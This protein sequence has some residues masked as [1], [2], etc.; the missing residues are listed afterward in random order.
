VTLFGRNHGKSRQAALWFSRV[1]AG[2][3][4]DSEDR[5]WQQWMAAEADNPEA[6]DNVELAWQLA[7]ELR[8]RPQIQGLLHDIDLKFKAGPAAAAKT[9]LFGERLSWRAAAGIAALVLVCVVTALVF[10]TRFGAREY[11]TA[12]GEQRTMVLA[13][14][15]RISLNT[16]TRVQVRY[17][18]ALRHIDL[19]GGEAVFTVTP[20]S[21][22]PFEV[23]ALRGTTTAVGT[24]FDVR[25]TGATAEVSV[26]QGEVTVRPTENP[27]DANA[28]E[29]FAGQAEEY[30][31]DGTTSAIHG[32]DAD[33]IHG[34]LT[35]R[36]V[37]GDTALA[38][39]LA[40]YNRYT[41]TPIV[42]GKPSLGERRISGVFRIGDQAAFLNALEQ[43]LTVTATP[44]GAGIVLQPR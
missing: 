12:V 4:D 42:I 26:L 7:E 14:N 23:H 19:L 8:D 22:R 20:D 32:A 16:G 5:D 39:A 41:K 44:V 24:E 40:D 2:L 25:V 30:A 35:Q 18:G 17:S 37:F 31:V 36:I 33:K 29:I 27:N 9:G 10:K 3:E 15:S 13:D 43:Q 6:Y 11:A 34:W 1:R 38:E 28:R 21:E